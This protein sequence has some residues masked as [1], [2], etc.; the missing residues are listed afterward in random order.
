VR[1]PNCKRSRMPKRPSASSLKLCAIRVIGQ[2][3]TLIAYGCRSLE[4]VGHVFTSTGASVNIRISY[5]LCLISDCICTCTYQMVHTILLRIFCVNCRLSESRTYLFTACSH[6]RHRLVV[7][8]LFEDL[9][10][11]R[12]PIVCSQPDC[13]IPR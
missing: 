2:H 3:F 5:D 10:S 4:Q 9:S 7:V 13:R 1:K 12:Q 8:K 6:G 11:S